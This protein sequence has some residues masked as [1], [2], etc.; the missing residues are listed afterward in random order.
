MSKLD[1]LKD[2]I[3]GRIKN[4]EN[5]EFLLSVY[6]TITTDDSIEKYQFTKEQLE[7]LNQSEKD[8]ENG[9]LISAE[10]LEKIDSEWMN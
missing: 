1:K 10:E 5:E 2:K 7:M 4:S 9:D 8:I 3:I 6:N